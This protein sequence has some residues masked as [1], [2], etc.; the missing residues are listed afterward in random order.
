MTIR[1]MFSPMTQ[2]PTGSVSSGSSRLG[3]SGGR[4]LRL[5]L[6][7]F[8][9]GAET[10]NA[11]TY[12]DLYNFGFSQTGC[13]PVYPAV[14]AQGRDG[15]IYGTTV[16]GGTNGVGIVFKI[17]PS[18]SLT[19]LYNFDTVH[20]S[21]PVG[22][23]ALGVDG[24][25][26][27][28]TEAGGAHGYG[29][30]FRITPSGALTVIYNFTGKADGGYPV[31]PL[32]LGLDGT[33]HGISYPDVA[34]RVTTAGLFTVVVGVVT[35][36]PT[37]SYGQLLQAKNGSFYGVTQFGG[38]KSAGTIFK[39]TGTTSTILYNFDGTHGAYPIGGLAEGTDGNLYGTTTA[40][41]ATNAGVIFRI[42]PAGVLTVLLS[43]DSA[44]PLGGY[45]AYAGLVAGSDGNL[46][47][48]TIW[49]GNYGYGVIFRL[50]TSGAYSVL[51]HFSAP[52]GDGAYSTPM[53]H[54]NGEIFG[55]T[56]RGGAGGDGVIYSFSDSLTPFA[57]LT[58]GAGAVSNVVG[59]L[60][61]GLM[62]TT[63]VKFGGT[64]ATFTVVS[65]TYLTAKVPAGTT[66][67]VSVAT[68]S[69]TLLSSKIFKV[70]PTI[71]GF[72]PASGKVGAKV[73]IAGTGLIQTNALTVGG[74][75]VTAFT[76][77]SDAKVTF[78]VPA[79]AKTGKIVVTTPGGT[80][81][82]AAVFTVTP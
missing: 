59:I 44:H 35:T 22:G 70:T 10:L 65:D 29:N 63:G 77:N 20:G 40:G 6:L 58:S 47:G 4:A 48:T 41:G 72:T 45:Q 2:P 5:F 8:V 66:G 26:Y 64:S 37:V 76:K 52:S 82:S 50:T 79:A 73:T 67:T 23:L 57:R 3:L 53:E 78:I 19:T 18:G 55:M 32:T 60:G 7:F 51:Y 17:T 12:H 56:V 80:A 28:T 27:G 30:I 25:L 62:G 68:A 33:F 46:Y 16:R 14:M 13:C 31:A 69:G 11:Q 24:N 49:G 36:V 71:S 74:V 1:T 54:T 9:L 15:N 75:K 61:K 21:T 42:T 39:I 81:T 38:T 34:F 43:F